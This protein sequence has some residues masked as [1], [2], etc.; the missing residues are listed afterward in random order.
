MGDK[1]DRFTDLSTSVAAFV[2]WP[3][4]HIQLG[5]WHCTKRIPRWVK[6]ELLTMMLMWPRPLSAFLIRLFIHREDLANWER[7]AAK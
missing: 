4:D 3:T 2:L 1:I 6:P 5:I 7:S